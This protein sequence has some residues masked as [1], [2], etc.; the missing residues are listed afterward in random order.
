M[1]Y[2]KTIID[3]VLSKW[4][5]LCNIAQNSAQKY[6]DFTKKQIKRNSVADDV[7]KL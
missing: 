7:Q 1:T 3:S 4:T 2:P 6:T 5:K